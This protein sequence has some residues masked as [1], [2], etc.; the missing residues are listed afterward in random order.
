MEESQGS[1]MNESSPISF[2]HVFGIILLAFVGFFLS[3][4]ILYH[5]LIQ[6]VPFSGMAI[7]VEDKA[8]EYPVMEIVGDLRFILPSENPEIQSPGNEQRFAVSDA[9]EPVELSRLL[10][11]RNPAFLTWTLLISILVALS[12]SLGAVIVAQR[13]WL[14]EASGFTGKQLWI[15]GGLLLLFALALYFTGHRSLYLVSVAEW[16]ERLDILLN[17][18]LDTAQTYI[19]IAFVP[20]TL[21]IWGQLLVSRSADQLRLPTLDRRN[22]ALV[23]DLTEHFGHLRQALRLFLVTQGILVAMAILTTDALRRSL[24]TETQAILQLKGLPAVEL[25]LVPPQ[26]VYLYGLFFSVILATFYIPVFFHLRSKGR[27]LN[28]ALKKYASI[29]DDMEVSL[30]RLE[31]N[32]SVMDNLKMALTILAP[33]ISSFLPDLITL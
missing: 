20:A 32:E 23:R 7:A 10:F 14:F 5:H 17:H 24:L 18:P 27:A 8:S 33:L 4:S 11:H 29:P 22:V 9:L 19:G 15:Q 16:M 28:R 12:L 3:T 31:M 13:R 26:F 21:A 1:P 2:Y 30:E 25:S 6:A